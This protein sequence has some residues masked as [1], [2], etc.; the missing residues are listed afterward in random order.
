MFAELIMDHTDTV[1]GDGGITGNIT[2]AT[3]GV[4]QLKTV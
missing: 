1:E 4:M 3:V 2:S